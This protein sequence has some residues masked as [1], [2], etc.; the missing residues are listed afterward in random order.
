MMALYTDE[1]EYYVEA[2][3]DSPVPP[4]RAQDFPQLQVRNNSIALLVLCSH[5]D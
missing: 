5:E 1:D 2:P 4:P 3:L